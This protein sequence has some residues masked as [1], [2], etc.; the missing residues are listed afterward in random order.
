MTRNS[1]CRR[2]VVMRATAGVVLSPHPRSADGTLDAHVVACPTFAR[3]GEAVVV[4]M[5]QCVLF[6]PCV[7]Q[8]RYSAING[9][10]WLTQT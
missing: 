4:L 8:A 10:Q 3:Q 5:M 7:K 1:R 2:D 6:A 9:S